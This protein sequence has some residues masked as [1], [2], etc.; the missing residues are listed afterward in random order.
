MLERVRPKVEKIETDRKTSNTRSFV[1][2]PVLLASQRCR[3]SNTKPWK[4]HAR[5][6]AGVA[7][8]TASR[9]QRRQLSKTDSEEGEQD[10]SCARE[11]VLKQVLQ[12][13]N[14]QFGK[15]SIMTIGDGSEATFGQVYVP[16]LEDRSKWTEPNLLRLQT[17]EHAKM[18][19]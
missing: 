17:P 3:C 7:K 6:L 1:A 8:A 11:R 4:T 15:G 10:L 5:V 9:G 18:R 19:C 2:R 13:I 16:D 14:S 12:E